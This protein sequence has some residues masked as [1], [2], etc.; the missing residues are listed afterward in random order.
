M[1]CLYRYPHGQVP[2]PIWD[3]GHPK[4]LYYCGLCSH[5]TLADNRDTLPCQYH[6]PEEENPYSFLTTEMVCYHTVGTIY[7]TDISQ[8]KWFNPVYVS[9]KD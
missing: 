7:E 8:I 5:I 9:N 2:V 6:E 3:P 1:R 4:E